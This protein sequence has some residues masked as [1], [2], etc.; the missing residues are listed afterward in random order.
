MTPQEML[1]NMIQK[2]WA[3]FNDIAREEEEDDYSDAMLSMDR[4]RAEGYAEG[5][6]TAYSLIFNEDYLP[7]IEVE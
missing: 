2:A 4:T 3:E 6:S 1:K 5:L 7:E